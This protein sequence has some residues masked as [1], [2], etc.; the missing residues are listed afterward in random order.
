MVTHLLET[1]AG[2]RNQLHAERF[3][4]LN[5]FGDD[6]VFVPVDEEVLLVLIL[7]DAHL[8]I[9]VV[10]HLVVVAIQMVGCNVHDDRDV[11][12]EVIHVV[13]LETGQF[14]DVVVKV[15]RGHLVG[16][17][18]THISCQTYIETSLLQDMVSHHGGGGLAIRAC[19]ANHLGIGVA[20]SELNLGDNGCT[21]LEEFHHQRSRER[22]ARALDNLV[23]IQYQF[24][25]ML[26]TLFVGDIPTLEP[27]LVLVFDR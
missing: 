22:N 14:D 4:F 27:F 6:G 12:L 16:Q 19:D 20:T 13:Q 23:G 8:G 1:L 17:R 25:C 7:Q 18:L 24:G 2:E 5:L 21:F 15:L 10:L 11:G 3:T 9:D 26:V